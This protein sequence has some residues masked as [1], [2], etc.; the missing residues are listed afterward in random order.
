MVGKWEM[1]WEDCGVRLWFYKAKAALVL[2]EGLILIDSDDCFCK[3]TLHDSRTT[4]VA[5]PFG[6]TTLHM[7]QYEN[8]ESTYL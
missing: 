5:Y 1:D 6:K 8:S 3:P 7:I 4:E 2:T